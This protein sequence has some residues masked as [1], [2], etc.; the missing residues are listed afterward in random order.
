MTFSDFWETYA[1]V[2]GLLGEEHES[3]GKETGETEHVERWNNTRR[4][5][6]G[7]FVRKILSLSKSNAYHKVALKVFNHGYNGKLSVLA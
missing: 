5:R 7:R 4:Q 6:L 2:F 3:V 1:Q